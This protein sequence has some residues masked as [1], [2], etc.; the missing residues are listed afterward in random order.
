M[1]T[2][3]VITAEHGGN[4]VPAEYRPL[5][6]H[7]GEVLATHRGWDPGSLELAELF[8]RRLKAPLI[9]AK[10]TRLLVDLN[11]GPSNRA[12]FSEFTRPLDRE[13]RQ[14]I[15]NRHH[16]PHRTRVEATVSSLIDNGCRV[17]HLG[18]H[19]FTPELHGEVRNADIGFLYDP[20]RAGERGLCLAWRKALRAA[21]P[22]LRVRMNYPYLGT[23]DGLTTTLRSRFPARGY[24]GLEV[25]VNQ[26]WPQGRLRDWP[27]LQASLLES[28]L[29]ACDE[30]MP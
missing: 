4:D 7:A 24:A 3:F 14:A 25:E 8:A 16:T 1:T 30:I 15:L 26:L 27:V 11:R 19:S 5:F 2:R 29:I 12:V 28:F 23:S 22:D 20:S 21:R 18:M 6:Q 17:V 9:A 10:V 13:A